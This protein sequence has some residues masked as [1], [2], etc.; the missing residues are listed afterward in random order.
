MQYKTIMP[1][2]TKITH[3]YFQR[4]EIDSQL[5]IVTI[6]IVEKERKNA[7]LVKIDDD[8]IGQLKLKM[9]ACTTFQQEEI[10]HS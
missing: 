5:L 9:L 3:N 2:H 6:I 1:N 8:G 4:F 10:G 7:S